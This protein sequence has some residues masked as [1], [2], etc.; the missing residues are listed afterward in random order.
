MTLEIR[1]DMLQHGRIL[2]VAM[3]DCGFHPP[4][5]EMPRVTSSLA[6]RIL[7]LL[8]FACTAVVLS[9]CAEQTT[10]SLT[11]DKNQTALRDGKPLLTVDEANAPE[12][13]NLIASVSGEEIAWGH[14]ESGL[15][16]FTYHLLTGLRG[17]SASLLS[18]GN[19]DGQISELELEDWVINEA[20]NYT[21]NSNTKRIQ[22]PNFQGSISVLLPAE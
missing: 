20:E 21:A 1:S 17:D 4:F 10:S 12:G 16:V 15:S 19:N 6:H 13:I 11:A 7:S 22:T 8:A 3:F 14:D 18:G 9:A 5:I 2:P